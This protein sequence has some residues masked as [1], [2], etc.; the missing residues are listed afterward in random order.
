MFQRG[1]CKL[2]TK[3]KSLLPSSFVFFLISTNIKRKDVKR[4]LSKGRNCSKTSDGQVVLCS[5][6]RFAIKVRL[7]TSMQSSPV[8]T[9]IFWR[10]SVILHHSEYLSKSFIRSCC[11][12]AWHCLSIKSKIATSI[13]MRLAFSSQEIVRISLVPDIKGGYWC[14]LS[15]LSG[16]ARIL[17]LGPPESVSKEGQ[18][19]Y[20]LRCKTQ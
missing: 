5:S 11:W 6:N 1:L 15:W 19:S 18:A 14:L 10:S 8:L 4:Y 13:S 7:R 20:E 16:S 12:Y 17:T 3:T 2:H 9:E